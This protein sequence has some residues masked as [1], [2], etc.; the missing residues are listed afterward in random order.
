MNINATLFL[1]AIVFAILVWFTMKF[2]WP[3]ITKAL[4]ERAQKI[5]DGLAAA[6]KA[7][8]ELANANK[9]VEAELATSRNETAT[10]LA[11]AERRAQTIVEEAKARA[12]EEG[13]RIIAAAK[14]E[15]EQ[16]SVKA[17]DA[18]REQVAALAVKGAEQ[19]LR[20]EVNAGVHA[21]L[22]SR[23]KTEL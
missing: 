15:A 14:A 22:L 4:D 7:K 3:P 11:D 2:V 13:N 17:R 9:R 8:A 18:L 19:I 12:V 23:L 1:Q 21:D 20:K 5:A 16:Q 10:R 6:D